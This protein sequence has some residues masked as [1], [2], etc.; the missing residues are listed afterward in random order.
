MYSY[1]R[2]T[3][4]ADALKKPGLHEYDVRTG[5]LTVT[6]QLD[7]PDPEDAGAK[8]ARPSAKVIVD[9]S[10]VP[11]DLLE[12]YEDDIIAAVGR[13]LGKHVRWLEGD[14]DHRSDEYT[15]YVALR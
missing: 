5:P 10:M 8:K 2:R 13:F 3:A 12:E 4:G 6:L 14:W 15:R 9:K 11:Q 1:D 7:V